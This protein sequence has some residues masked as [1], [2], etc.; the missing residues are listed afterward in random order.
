MDGNEERIGQIAISLS[1]IQTEVVAIRL[2]LEKS[3][4][5][6]GGIAFTFSLLGGAMAMLANWLLAKMG[7]V[8]G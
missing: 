6:M 1:S 5:F 3:M 8:G 2:K 7:V 4:S